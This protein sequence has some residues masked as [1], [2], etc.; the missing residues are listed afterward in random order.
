METACCMLSLSIAFSFP[1]LARMWCFPDIS[2]VQWR[3]KTILEM[4]SR[5]EGCATSIFQSSLVLFCSTWSSIFDSSSKCSSEKALSEPN[6][7]AKVLSPLYLYQFSSSFYSESELDIH[8]SETME[9]SLIVSV[10][11]ILHIQKKKG[12]SE[13]CLKGRVRWSRKKCLTEQKSA[14][15]K[16]GLIQ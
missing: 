2:A 7:M 3:I 15:K 11:Q 1:L 13:C 5:T 10:L 6:S 12:K 16:S 14:K 8:L 4:I 9:F